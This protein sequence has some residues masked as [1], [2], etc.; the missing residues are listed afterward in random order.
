MDLDV[1]LYGL[2]GGFAIVG[3]LSGF[4]NQAWRLGV[5]VLA[6]LLA[7]FVSAALGPWLERTTGLAFLL[8]TALGFGLVFIGAY[9]A[10]TGLIWIVLR[11]YRRKKGIDPT[12]MHLA[13]RI[14]GGILGGVKGFLLVFLLLCAV[15]WMEN[16][17]TT[18]QK[19]WY[20]QS[21]IVELVKRHNILQ[22]MELPLVGKVGSL[23]RQSEDAAARDKV[24]KAL[25]NPKIQGLLTDP[26]AKRILQNYRV[27]AILQCPSLSSALSDPEVLA[28]LRALD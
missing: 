23:G 19:S 16:P 10:I 15:V 11:W 7:T 24:K 18:D 28:L 2:V 14:L 6:Y 5:L 13:D 4:E 1:M 21:R 8:A 17:Q 20:R 9:G 12:R 25:Q 27:G 3:I 26:A 22:G